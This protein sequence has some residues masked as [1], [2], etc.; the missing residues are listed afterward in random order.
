MTRYDGIRSAQFI[1]NYFP[2]IDGV[3][4]TVHS[5]AAHMDAC[6]V[7]P[8]MVRGYDKL[9]FPYEVLT[10][11]TL[12]APF[13]EHACALPAA[14]ARLRRQLERRGADIFH[15]HSPVT[16]GRYALSLGRELGIPVVATFHSKYYDAVLEVTK[17]RRI[18]SWLTEKVVRFYE[19][20]DSV[21]ACSEGTAETLRSY[22][23][24]GDIFIMTNGTGFV[25]PAKPEPLADAAAARFGL[26]RDKRV[27]LFVGQMIWYKNQRLMLDAFRLLCDGSD[28]YCL[29]MVGSGY[30]EREI[31][32]YAAS[33]GLTPRQVIFTGLIS[34]RALLEGVYLNADL[35]FFPSVFD[36]TPLVVREAA[37]MGVPSLL[38]AGSNAAESVV[39]D[40]NG[41]TASEDA[42]AMRDELTRIFAGD[43]LL[44]RVGAAARETIPIRWET[45]IPRVCE[46]YG[47]II[48]RYSA[49]HK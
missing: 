8:R 38:T 46:K 26:P 40:V 6:V 20:C 17:S 12:R 49:A 23:Y 39:K 10:G 32:A 28:E 2:V 1:D 5:Y 14:N 21:W 41:F 42:A 35:L 19:S 25:R 34:D 33:L 47:E 13:A 44:E 4:Q 9:D 37:A 45:L 22:G 43:G 48:E 27:L 7:C 30:N 16:L 36:N 11:L 31:R 29:V 3:I 24:R 18:A 15:A